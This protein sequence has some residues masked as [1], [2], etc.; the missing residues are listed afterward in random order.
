MKIIAL[1]TFKPVKVN[2]KLLDLFNHE[3]E[4]ELVSDGP[5]S[6]YIRIANE[7]LCSPAN[8]SYLQAESKKTSSPVAGKGNGKKS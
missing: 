3:T 6:G 1:Q 5:F 4:M 8:I 7:I 2:G